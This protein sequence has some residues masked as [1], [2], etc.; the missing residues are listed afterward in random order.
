MN[1]STP[2]SSQRITVIVV[3][4]YVALL[5]VLLLAEFGV[6]GL[7]WLRATNQVLLLLAL[8][9]LPFLLLAAS[10]TVR[11]ISLKVSGQEF[12]LDLTELQRSV[13]GDLRRIES[14]VAGQLSTAEQSLWPILAG[15]DPH[16]DRRWRDGQIVIGSK[17]DSSQIFLGYLLAA[18]LERRLPSVT[19]I[20]RVPNGGSLKNF[21]DLRFGWIDLYVDYTGTSIQYFNL[22]HRDK[23]PATLLSEL[24]AFGA[25][26]G[27][28]WLGLLGASEGYRLVV[29]RERAER[30]GLSTI[31]DLSRV[32]D[33][34][35][36]SADAEFLNR[37]D[38]YA[39]LRTVY[40]LAFRRIELCPITNRYTHLES[41]EAD[42]F[43]GF[44]TDPELQSPTLIALRDVDEFFPDYHAVPIASHGALESIKGL[45]EALLDLRDSVTTEDLMTIAQKL[46]RR[47]VQP[48]VVR[49]LAREFVGRRRVNA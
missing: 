15:P 36:L 40:D 17:L 18:H 21:A 45:R 7:E 43:I 20:L 19:C 12:H 26:L 4:A 14:T 38:G 42:V 32:S 13:A 2:S 47:G 41:G 27:V 9:F 49:E 39:G 30:E 35:V 22:A 44:E 29:R 48:A 10:Q 11:S 31:R 23:T 34:L 8:L 24:N 5:L 3:A 46:D 25:G 6:T 28:E 16:R 37:R 33:Q 1:E